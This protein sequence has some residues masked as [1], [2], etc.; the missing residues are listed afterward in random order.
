MSTYRRVP[1]A[2]WRALPVGVVVRRPGTQ[3]DALT[4]T[5]PAAAVWC[6]LD[7][8]RTLDELASETPNAVEVIEQ[9]S[10]AGLVT[11]EA[12]LQ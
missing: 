11:V 6:A 3:R 4:L 12:Q 8:S 1:G 7:R 9:L 10:D 2:V 5:G